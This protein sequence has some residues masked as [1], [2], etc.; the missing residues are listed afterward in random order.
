VVC[1]GA[2]SDERCEVR[3]CISTLAVVRGG[4]PPFDKGGGEL[5]L[6]ADGARVV[7]REVARE[8]E[9]ADVGRV[10]VLVALVEDV[11]DGVALDVDEGVVVAEAV[12]RDAR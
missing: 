4:A 11:Q 5:Q 7:E 6:V 9:E 10:L 12:L 3:C 1:G 2:S 8:V